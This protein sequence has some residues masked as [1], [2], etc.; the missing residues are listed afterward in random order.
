MNRICLSMIVKNEAP[1]IRRC[2]DSVRPIIDSW[3]IVDTGSSDGTQQM[4]REH[5]ADLP[6]Q[7][8]ERPWVDFAHNRSEALELSRARGEYSFVI[9]ADEVLDLTPGFALPEL[10]LDSYNGAVH[11]GGCSYQRKMLVKNALPWRYEGILHEYLRCDEAK[12][13][14]Y[15]EGLITK[16]H[17]DGARA[18]DPQT[19][20][21]DALLL[22]RALLDD[23][24]N[25]RY[26]FYL[27]QSYRDAGDHELAIRWYRKRAALGGWPDE[28]WYS[29]YQ[30]AQLEERQGTAWPEVMEAK[31]SPN[32][33]TSPRVSAGGGPDCS[34][35]RRTA[36][37][38][39]AVSSRSGRPAI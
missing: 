2:L 37:S 35:F 26:V 8:F 23:P 24:Q 21:R 9:D 33:R 7:L 11:Y 34:I 29:L 22:E 20:R 16:P 36:S 13:E 19:Y 15:L 10:T 31:R 18:R 6:G 4:I 17:R 30:I 25:A 39:S 32:L 38:V 28:A 27:A 1:V 12:T 5:L 3:V 14:Q